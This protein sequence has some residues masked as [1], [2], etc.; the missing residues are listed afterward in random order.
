MSI[1]SRFR[2]ALTRPWR[3]EEGSVTV[4]F[5]IVFPF[6]LSLLLMAIDSGITQLR[7]VFLHRAVDVAVR[8]VRLGRVNEADSMADLICERTA[9]LPSCRQNIA[10]EMQPI[11]TETFAGLDAPNQCV[12]RETEITPAVTFNP[13]SGGQAQ[14]LML[15]RVCVVADPFIRLTGFITALPVNGDGDYVLISNSVFVNEPR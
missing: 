15:I 7:Q 3:A 2:T 11:D 1:V 4:E 12:D 9:L 13:G 6:V 10:V 8:E 5:V 14:E